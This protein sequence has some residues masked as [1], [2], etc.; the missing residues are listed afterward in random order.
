MDIEDIIEKYKHHGLRK[1][2]DIINDTFI[3][4][5][6]SRPNDKKITWRYVRD[7]YLLNWDFHQLSS[8]KFK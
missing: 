3:D 2:E 6:D 7:A 8:Y 5:I 1:R 4:W